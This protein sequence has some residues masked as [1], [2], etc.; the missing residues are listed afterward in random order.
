MLILR[1]SLDEGTELSKQL[2]EALDRWTS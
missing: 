2:K 1:D